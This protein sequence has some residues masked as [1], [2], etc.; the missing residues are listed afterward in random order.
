MKKMNIVA[1]A[2]IVS[3]TLGAGVAAASNDPAATGKVLSANG[4]VLIQRN[5]KTDTAVIG[6]VVGVGDTVLTTDTGSSQLLMS[7]ESLFAI[8]PS[9]GLKINKYALPSQGKPGVASY[10][11]LQGS[12]HTITGKIGKTTAANAPRNVYSSATAQF[13]PANLVKVVAAPAGP[14]TLKTALGVITT[15]GADYVASQSDNVLKVLVSAGSVTACTVAGCAS[16]SAGQGL[17]VSCAGCKPSV[18]SASNL[19]IDDLVASLQFNLKVPS[20]IVTGVQVTDTAV[21]PVPAT[22]ACRTVASILQDGVRCGPGG[23]GTP[24]SPN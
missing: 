8:A 5:V 20:P 6:S 23:A 12:V 9:S 11:L 3:S 16:P 10:T 18:V 15:Q 24:V 4:G 22:Q 7:D 1:V 13:N 2:L 17:V 14:Y 21:E 19:G